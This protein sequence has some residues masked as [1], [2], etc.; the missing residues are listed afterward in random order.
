ME[1]AVKY[2]TCLLQYGH[3]H[4]IIM[5]LFCLIIISGDDVSDV[6]IYQ[7]NVEKRSRLVYSFILLSSVAVFSGER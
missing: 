1:S 6:P 3:L 4:F 5:I 2:E 7:G